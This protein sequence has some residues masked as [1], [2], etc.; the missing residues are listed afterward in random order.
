MIAILVASGCGGHAAT[1]ATSPSAI[2]LTL[3]HGPGFRPAAIG[4]APQRTRLPCGP[5]APRRFGVHIELFA[6]GHVVQVPAGIG[7]AP[8]VTRH[9]AYVTR[10]RCWYALH[11]TEPT[12]LINV[13]AGTTATLGTLFEIWRQPL[14]TRRLAG[15]RGA[16]RAYLSGR[17]RPGDPR[18]I[19][20]RRHAQ[21]VLEVG[22]LVPPHPTYRFPPGL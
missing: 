4:P 20:L 21:I 9:G 11:T 18:A 22:P 6:G 15:F 5:R 3:G 7:V 1:T 13:T 12:G 10:G 19:P 16:V 17:R 8:P 2:P 14:S